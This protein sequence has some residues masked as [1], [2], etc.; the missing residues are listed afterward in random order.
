MVPEKQ[1]LK[2]GDLISGRIRRISAGDAEIANDIIVV[3]Y[4]MEYKV[5]KLF[6]FWEQEI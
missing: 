2:P 1:E 3:D 6:G 5:D 4:Y